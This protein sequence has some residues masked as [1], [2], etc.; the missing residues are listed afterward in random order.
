MA[1]T[2]NYQ[3]SLSDL[4]TGIVELKEQD[5]IVTGITLDS[6][7]VKPGDLFLACFGQ[8]VDGRNFI[9]Q[10][11]ENGASAV[12]AEK[13]TFWIAPLKEAIP[14]IYVDNLIPHLAEIAAKFY[15]YPAHRLRLIGVT[16]TNGKTSCTQFLAGALQGLQQQSAVIGTLGYGVYGQLQLGRHTT[17]EPLTLQKCL[18]QYADQGMQTVSM[19]VTSH[20]LAQ[21]RIN[22]LAYA[23]SVFTNLSRDHLDYHGTMQA[24]G[25]CKLKLFTESTA[26]HAVINIDDPFSKKILAVL[27]E[28]VKAWTYGIKNPQADINALEINSLPN[29]IYAQIK[30]PW[31]EGELTSPLLGQFNVSNLL[32][33][34][35]RL[36]LLDI[37]FE[38][39]LSQLALQVAPAGRME[40]VAQGQHGTIVVDYAHTPDALEHALG[41]LRAHCQ[42]DLWSVFGCGGDRDRGKRP[43]MGKVANE[44]ADHII[45]TDDNPRDEDR[46]QIVDDII[47]GIDNTSKLMIENDRKA[48]IHLA[49]EKAK[50]NDIVLIAGKGHEAY[51][52]IADQQIPMSDVDLVQ[53]SL[54]KIK[55][56]S[57]S[58]SQ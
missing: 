15:Q 55:A 24:Y 50:A 41:A 35:A 25:A 37:P 34:L 20:A 29:G 52:V 3:A 53:E 17:P 28:S 8:E 21:G 12:V 2:V 54:Q 5:C 51:Q 4:L 14:I 9:S 6:R 18:A 10:A 36:C 19:E 39:A 45:L 42:G 23:I 26:E 44:Y 38:A 49:L 22:G 32:A 47:A 1:S 56:K 33:S 11:I 57:C 48:A 13:N 31:G 43:M 46:Q 40:V 27:P 30:T 58:A 7:E 16:G